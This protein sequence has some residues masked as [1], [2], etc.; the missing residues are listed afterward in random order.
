MK[1]DI[2]S[3]LGF[4][5]QSLYEG[6]KRTL[7]RLK[8]KNDE[9]ALDAAEREVKRQAHRSGRIKYNKDTRKE[10]EFNKGIK[11]SLPRHELKREEESIR[12]LKFNRQ[13]I[14]LAAY[15]NIPGDRYDHF[16]KSAQLDRKE[17]SKMGKAAESRTTAAARAEDIYNEQPVVKAK[18]DRAKD[19]FLK[20]LLRMQ[21]LGLA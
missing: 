15:P 13:G 12:A 3:E 16:N 8:S 10:Y 11:T 9:G 21:D 4:D 1:N 18:D 19:N 2:Y 5:V 20:T 7:R 17:L 6:L 14:A